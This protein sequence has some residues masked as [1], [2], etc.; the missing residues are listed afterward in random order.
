MYVKKGKGKCSNTLYA[1]LRSSR[2]KLKSTNFNWILIKH[3][4]IG[5]PFEFFEKNHHWVHTAHWLTLKSGTDESFCAHLSKLHLPLSNCTSKICQSLIGIFVKCDWNKYVFTFLPGTKSRIQVMVNRSIKAQ[6]LERQ[7]QYPVRV[8]SQGMAETPH[9]FHF[10][11]N[12]GGGI[13]EEKHM[14]THTSSSPTL[15]GNLCTWAL[16]LG[17]TSLWT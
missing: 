1:C 7:L 14:Y 4:Y 12:S 5:V 17:P 8:K 15:V 16:S 10:Y 9:T 6:K 2:I 13:R 3:Q 11:Q